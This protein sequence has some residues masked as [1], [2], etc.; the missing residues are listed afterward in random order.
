MPTYEN[1]KLFAALEAFHKAAV[2]L[3]AAWE[4]TSD[5]APDLPLQNAYPFKDSFSEVVADISTWASE[6]QKAMDAETDS[7]INRADTQLRDLLK[8]GCYTAVVLG[9]VDLH[10]NCASPV[11]LE[12]LLRGEVIG[13]M[14]EK[15]MLDSPYMG[16]LATLP[17]GAVVHL[18]EQAIDSDWLRRSAGFYPALNLTDQGHVTLSSFTSKA[19]AQ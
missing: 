2:E 11:L 10:P 1:R 4:G 16:A 15:Q 3:E 6:A 17:P 19:V 18:I 8:A 7:E 13:R 9:A 5:H 12:H 14:A